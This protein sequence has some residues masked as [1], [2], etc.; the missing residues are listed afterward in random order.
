MCLLFYICNTVTAILKYINSDTASTIVVINGL[1]ITAGS[2]PSFLAIIGREQPIT[3]ATHT[4][5]TKVEQTTS[6][7]LVVTPSISNSFAKLAIARVRPIKNDTLISFQI[8]LKISLNS[9]SFNDSPRIIVA[10]A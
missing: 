7:T 5:R 9:I 4:V 1:A 2:N 3:L 10:D 6:A 8:T